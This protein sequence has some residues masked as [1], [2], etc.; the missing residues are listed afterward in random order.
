MAVI[1]IM[2][3]MRILIADPDAQVLE[4]FRPALSEGW[5]PTGVGTGKAALAEVKERSYDVLV[6]SVDLPDISGPELLNRIRKRFPKTAR[7][8][9]AAEDDRDRVLKRMLGAHQ[10]IAK[11][12]DPATLRSTLDRTRML[13]GWMENPGVRDLVGRV[14]TVPSIPSLYLEVLDVLKSP[15]ATAEEVGAIIAK[16]MAMTT[17]LLQVLNSAYFGFSRKITDPAEAVGLLGFS[18]VKSMVV[19]VKMLGQYDKSMPEY[20]SID[21]LWRHSTEVA[22]IAKKITIA[23]TNDRGMADTAYTAGLLHDVGKVFLASNFGEQYEGVQSLALKQNVSLWEVEKE[24][25]G[26]SHGEISAY[27]LG[28]WGMPLDLIEAAAYH[29]CPR[30]DKETGF[31]P[32]TAVHVANVFEHVLNADEDAAYPHEID[33]LYLEELGLSDRIADWRKAAGLESTGDSEPADDT[34]PA[35]DLALADDSE[36]VDVVPQPV[37]P[38]ECDTGPAPGGANDVES[39]EMAKHEATAFPRKHRRLYLGAAAAVMLFLVGTI[40]GY[41]L[42]SSTEGGVVLSDADQDS[43][44]DMT[45]TD[46]PTGVS[47]LE[48]RPAD[49]EEPFLEVARVDEPSV[50]AS[51]SG[52]WAEIS[53]EQSVTAGDGEG[54]SSPDLRLQV[55][56]YSQ[57]RPAAV[58]NGQV[59]YIDDIVAGARVVEIN[60]LDVLLEFEDRRI[61]L[62]IIAPVLNP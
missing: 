1:S 15:N 59:V 22:R 53:D 16:D 54:P 26:A 58:I 19:A 11:P 57:D 37:K 2:E 10:F 42:S 40:A 5:E 32:Q 3:K 31:T 60:R 52:Q 38:E 12:V 51:S 18:T 45:M 17:K 43:G 25:F 29:H 36:S 47:G 61:R 55:I 28:L 20:F 44:R 35:D 56:Y 50:E 41:L 48:T 62:Q 49:P 46:A 30:G 33:A 7:F 8:I 23:E 24:V 6:A 13:D 9:L 34:E 21:R 4:G 27:L 39:D 14:R